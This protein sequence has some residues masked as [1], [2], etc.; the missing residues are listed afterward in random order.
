[1][2]LSHM[3]LVSGYGPYGEMSYGSPDG[4]TSDMIAASHLDAAIRGPGALSYS[5][6]ADPDAPGVHV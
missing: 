3:F 1:M 6:E 4:R 5:P 2:S